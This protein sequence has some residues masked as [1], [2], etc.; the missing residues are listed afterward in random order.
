MLPNRSFRLQSISVL[1]IGAIL[2]AMVCSGSGRSLDAM[3][4][5]DASAC[6]VGGSAAFI[7]ITCAAKSSLATQTGGDLQ[8]AF[9]VP[10]RCRMDGEQIA[11]RPWHKDQ[12]PL[13]AV[14]ADGPSAHCRVHEIH[15]GPSR[16]IADHQPGSSPKH[17]VRSQE[18]CVSF[19]PTLA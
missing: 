17:R 9:S 10:T 14:I 12:R 19:S 7:T 5:S 18:R 2:G 16:R 8:T 11:L 15:R 4:T 13:Q 6:L 3:R 1:R